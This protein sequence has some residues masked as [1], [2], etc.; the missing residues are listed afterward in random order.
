MRLFLICSFLLL[1]C[2]CDRKIESLIT[3]PSIL[4][5][6]SL[7]LE[8]SLVTFI[9]PEIVEPD[10]IQNSAVRSIVDKS[11]LDDLDYIALNHGVVINVTPYLISELYVKNNSTIRNIR[12]GSL[13]FISDFLALNKIDQRWDDTVLFNCLL[14]SRTGQYQ[15][16]ERG[17][18][19]DSNRLY[20]DSQQ[21]NFDKLIQVYDQL[22]VNAPSSLS[23][24]MLIMNRDSDDNNTDFSYYDMTFNDYAVDIYSDAPIL[25]KDF[26]YYKDQE[27]YYSHD[28]KNEP[29][30]SSNTYFSL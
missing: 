29:I 23:D 6:S 27:F 1:I 12:F 4:F 22:V 10:Y 9:E 17:K 19:W 15:L 8:S 18:L 7:K 14:S 11:M 30:F 25:E 21:R 16:S 3:S 20:V 24:I 2:A 13:P 28:L 5:N 26:N